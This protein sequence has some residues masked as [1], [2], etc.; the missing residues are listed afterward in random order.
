MWWKKLRFIAFVGLIGLA[1]SAPLLSSD[2]TTNESSKKLASNKSAKNKP[3]VVE[4]STPT[5]DVAKQTKALKRA[6]KLFKKNAHDMQ[7]AV[8]DKVM[9]TLRCAIENN[10][11]HNNILTV[12][13]Y[14]LPSSQK[15][16]WVFDLPKS[17]LLYH[18]YVS[19]GL[20]SGEAQP[21]F[22]SNVYNSKASSL[23]VFNTEKK[24][25]GR[26]GIA[27]K[28][29][30][31]EKSINDNAY[32]RFIVLHGS[33]YVNEDFIKKYGRAGRSWGCP[34]LPRNMVTPIINTIKDNSIMVVYYPS[35]QWLDKSEFLSCKDSKINTVEKKTLQQH[36]EDRGNVIYVDINGNDQ[37]DREEPVV[38]I[39]ADD[40]QDSFNKKPPL[41]RML[42]RQ[43]QQN[44]YIV[45]NTDEFDKLHSDKEK[46]KLI[47]IVKPVVKKVRGFYA[48]E[49]HFV[50]K[51]SIKSAASQ[52]LAVVVFSNEKS[53]SLKPTDKFI[54]W[55]GL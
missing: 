14:S 31:L 16:F 4:E 28:L 50:N 47:Y 1:L 54:R 34:S 20:K 2:S 49:M 38:V 11:D 42:R 27:L 46:H 7:P 52:D 26:Y 53:A 35:D 23:G 17:K 40:Y 48:T 6:E 43:I 37:R 3:A 18:T 39:K 12:I 29:L 5:I 15:R 32:N 24:Y 33:W 25:Y 36:S 21:T 19:H 51:K 10:V 55:L 22:F 41:K 9:R 44:E 30:G 45:L 13:D 8:V